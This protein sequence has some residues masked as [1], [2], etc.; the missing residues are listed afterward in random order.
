MKTS[1]SLSWKG[2][3]QVGLLEVAGDIEVVVVPEHLDHG[4]Q[5]R[6]GLEGAFDVDEG[7]RPG[8]LVP[9]RLIHLAV[10]DDRSGRPVTNVGPG[11]ERDLR[12]GDLARAG[13]RNEESRGQKDESQG[14]LTHGL[15]P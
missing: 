8:D 1:K 14:A 4:P 15:P 10:D 13:G 11:I 6:L 2:G 9:D 12:L 5:A 7:V 3:P